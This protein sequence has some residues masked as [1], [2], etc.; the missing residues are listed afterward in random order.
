VKLFRSVLYTKLTVSIESYFNCDRII[1][2]NVETFNQIHSL[3]PLQ[4]IAS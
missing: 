3:Q 4:P 2:Q 1:L